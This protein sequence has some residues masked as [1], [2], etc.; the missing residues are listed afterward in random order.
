MIQN[1]GAEKDLHFLKGIVGSTYHP[2][3]IQSVILYACNSFLYYT[4]VAS[5][6]A[7]IFGFAGTSVSQN[8]F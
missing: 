3:S 7:M 1:Y 2:A 8:I 5:T 4:A 6:Q